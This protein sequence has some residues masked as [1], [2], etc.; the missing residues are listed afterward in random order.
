MEILISG[1]IN[2]ATETIPPGSYERSS[3]QMLINTLQENHF[4]QL[5][6]ETTGQNSIIDLY[7][8][9]KP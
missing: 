6:R 3:S 2:W 1:D 8:K 4:C 5:Q 7:I 9:N